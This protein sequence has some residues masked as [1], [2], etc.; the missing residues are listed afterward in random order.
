MT[1]GSL[2]SHDLFERLNIS[3]EEAYINNSLQLTCT[4]KLLSLLPLNSM[5]LDVGCGTG[6]PVAVLL[7][8]AGHKITGFDISPRMLEFARTSVPDGNFIVADLL[9]YQPREKYGA[10]VIMFSHLQLSSWE[11]FHAA[12]WKFAEAVDSGGHLVIGTVTAD[13]FV[14]KEDEGWAYDETGTYALDYEVP[15]LGDMVKSFHLSKQG[16]EQFVLSLG[17]EIVYQAVDIFHPNHPAAVGEEQ[18]YII[19]R[20]SSNAPLPEP[21]PL[22]KGK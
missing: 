12:M 13:K 18:Q 5:I 7:S 10:V 4:H 17:L 9:S 21:K 8:S 1:P 15:F 19:A 6:R 14:A 2:A 22:P 3:Y 11:D 20:R 16:M